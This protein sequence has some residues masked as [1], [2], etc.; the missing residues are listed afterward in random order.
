MRLP[1]SPP[2]S[3]ISVELC[4]PLALNLGHPI[5]DCF[6]LALA[7][8]QDVPLVTADEAMIAA[9]RKAKVKVRRI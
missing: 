2:R 5:Y 9:A 3:Q 7:Q 6:Y 4:L 8:R 1:L